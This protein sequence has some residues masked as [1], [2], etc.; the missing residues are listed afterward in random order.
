MTSVFYEDIKLSD[1]SIKSIE[2]C[3]MLSQSKERIALD[4]KEKH[5][6]HKF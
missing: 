3:E 5:S 6:C 2:K 1:N 4:K